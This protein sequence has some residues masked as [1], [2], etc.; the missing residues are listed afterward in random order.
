MK[1]AHEY[2]W[3]YKE[4]GVDLRDLGCLM[5]DTESPVAEIKGSYEPYVSPDKKKFWLNGLSKDWHVTVRY[6]FL[7]GITRQHVKDVLSDLEV[8]TELSISGLDV[9]PSPY[10]DEKYNCLVAKVEDESLN[11]MNTAL[12]ILPNV[13][14]FPEYKAH[15][16]IGYFT[17][18]PE[19]ELKETVRTLY[20]DFGSVLCQNEDSYEPFEVIE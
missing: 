10:P 15:I 2:P 20:F 9:F 13:N 11:A 14:T 12:S 16:T 18:I 5:L 6:G 8:P 17:Q 1:N 19:I 4:W 7:Q 3:I